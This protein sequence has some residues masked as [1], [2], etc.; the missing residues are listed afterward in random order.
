M[1]STGVEKIA[2]TG[3]LSAKISSDPQ[4][5][6]Q[7]RVSVEPVNND[8]K[9]DG[10]STIK[11]VG[12]ITTSTSTSSEDE[13][14]DPDSEEFAGIPELVRNIVSFEDDP[15]L[16]VITFRSIFLSVVFCVVGSFV[17]QLS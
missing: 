6:Q 9:K 3:T 12:G 15:T 16:P 10:G 1:S 7:P 5:V 13:E 17:S 14:I 8:E 2:P 11:E 4:Q